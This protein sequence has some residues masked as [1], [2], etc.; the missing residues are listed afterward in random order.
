M[1]CEQGAG[2]RPPKD[3]AERAQLDNSEDDY[4]WVYDDQDAI[5]LLRSCPPGHRLLN[6]SGGVFKSELQACLPCGPAKYIIDQLGDC[7]DW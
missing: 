3:D 2:C 1:W 6:S 7:Q 5:F 4:L